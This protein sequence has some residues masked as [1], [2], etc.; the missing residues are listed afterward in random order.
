MA[1]YHSCLY[2]YSHTSSQHCFPAPSFHGVL[3][4]RLHLVHVGTTKMHGNFRQIEQGSDR[5]KTMPRPRWTYQLHWTMRK[6]FGCVLQRMPRNGGGKNTRNQKKINVSTTT[7]STSALLCLCCCLAVAITHAIFGPC[8]CHSCHY[9][10]RLL[11]KLGGGI[12]DSMKK[13][14]YTPVNGIE[15]CKKWDNEKTGKEEIWGKVMTLYQ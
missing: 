4:V 5:Q 2:P 13:T 1:C 3:R 12:G 6:Q 14:T 15:Q 10:L 9:S 7:A 11:T 8:F